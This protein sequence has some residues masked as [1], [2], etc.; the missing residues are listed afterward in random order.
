MPTPLTTERTNITSDGYD[1]N[2]QRYKKEARI[3]GQGN[4][5]TVDVATGPSPVASTTSTPTG[6]TSTLP[7]EKTAAQI[8]DFGAED[9]E[10]AAA[11]TRRGTQAKDSSNEVVDEDQVRAD[12]L[13]EMQA[14]I[15]A[16]N[17][18][19][20]DKLARAKTQGLGRLGSSTAI[21]GR[22]GLLGSD[23]GE[24]QTRT[25]EDGN[26]DVENS[27]ENEKLVKIEALKTQARTNADTEIAA[28]RAAKEAGL[29]D[30]IQYL[31]DA[32]TRKDTN[33]STVLQALIAQGL[34]PSTMDKAS[35]D[36]IAKGYGLKTPDIVNAYKLQKY[37]SDKTKTDAEA[38][39][40][41]DIED[42]LV[43]KGVT[44]I[45]EGNSGY[46]YDPVTKQYVLV[47]HV[48]KQ[49][50][51]G[52]GTGSGLG[53]SGYGVDASGKQIKISPR[54]Q[55]YVDA[56]NNGA[57]LDDILKGTSKEVQALRGE[58]VAGL[59]FQ[60]GQSKKTV[61]I[62]KEGKAI[63]DDLLTSGGSKALGGYSSV[64]GGQLTTSYGDA[65]A[66][67]SQLGA[68]LARDN[69]GLLKGSMSD[70][71]LQFIKDMSTGFDGQG[72]QSEKYINDRLTAIQTKLAEKI[73]SS[74]MGDAASTSTTPS[75]Q[76]VE[77][78]VG[79]GQYYNVD[80]NGDM[81]PVQ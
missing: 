52:T 3:D 11:L 6:G 48:N 58:V 46:K 7:T 51:P 40:K 63:V 22:R 43:K 56:V 24:A 53:T 65:K 2:G 10:L 60:G 27:I 77:Y 62:L 15:D 16:V 80:A 42:E 47:A 54:A 71:D 66:K 33:T 23:F 45:G 37:T 50:A 39:R 32:K 74:G 76:Q 30:Y 14:E 73:A 28:K 19:Y 9:P 68:I 69:L 49:F 21:Q 55:V 59:N 1:Y 26:T 72:I 67:A 75:V 70:K 34:D 31:Q 64:F 17:S 81:T 25:V 79:S 41:Q 8:Y 78:P 4:S 38:K 5:Y 36:A 44:S 35:I 61:D 20:A 12:K 13:A 18:V 29:N 57:N